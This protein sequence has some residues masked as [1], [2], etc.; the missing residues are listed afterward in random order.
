MNSD[1][2][3]DLHGAIMDLPCQPPQ[4]IGPWNTD[5]AYFS[6]H[7]D[8]RRAAA[9]LVLARLAAAGGEG[10]NEKTVPSVPLQPPQQ[11]DKQPDSGHSVVGVGEGFDTTSA[12][13]E[14]LREML[15]LV[16]FHHMSAAD[17]R[18]EHELGN[19]AAMPILRARAALTATA[20]CDAAFDFHGIAQLAGIK[21]DLWDMGAASLVYTEGCHGVAR[22]HFERFASLVR[23]AALC[24]A[25]IANGNVFR[26]A[27]PPLALTRDRPQDEMNPAV[28]SPLAAVQSEP[29][30]TE[31]NGKC[32][33]G[34]CGFSSC[35]DFGRCMADGDATPPAPVSAEPDAYVPIH[36]R[37]GP[38]WSMTASDPSP[39]RLPSSYP[40]RPVFFGPPAAV[41]GGFKLVPI[42]P[43]EDMLLAVRRDTPANA[44]WSMKWKALLDAAPTPA[45]VSAEPRKPL[46]EEQIIE[47]TE[48][49]SMDV[50]GCFIRI[51]RAIERAHG[52]GAG[53]PAGDAPKQP[54]TDHQTAP[55]QTGGPTGP[56][57]DALDAARYRF[58][59]SE[60]IIERSLDSK[61]RKGMMAWWMTRWAGIGK[62]GAKSLSLAQVDAL[63]DS[64][65]AETAPHLAAAGVQ[66]QDVRTQAV[67]VP[68]RAAAALWDAKEGRHE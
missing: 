9:K 3:G 6:G 51:A 43:T 62:T 50:P 57:S 40:L 1:N 31:W 18:R 12:L 20:K 66:K 58:I 14:A 65:I 21:L 23:T 56:A 17:L 61:G 28:S 19:E 53:K 36:P 37:N 46:T 44:T 29:A 35:E 15:P 34:H 42:V 49:I 64:A 11:T 24:E 30:P 8:A 25:D 67:S 68:T 13:R 32:V 27:S 7:W 2:A 4:H 22:A 41:P 39:E 38:L 10:S 48:H 55:V 26:S 59:R 16:G 60:M 52:I 63:L 54:S 5:M 47:A 45:A 33:M